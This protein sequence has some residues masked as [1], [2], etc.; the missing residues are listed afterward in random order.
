MSEPP[1]LP[2]SRDARGLITLTPNDKRVAE[3]AA[4]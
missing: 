3:W 2:S 1:L 4:R